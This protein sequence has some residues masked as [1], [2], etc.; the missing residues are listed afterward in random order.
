[1]QLNHCLH[2]DA[3]DN[4]ANIFSAGLTL[5]HASVQLAHPFRLKTLTQV[6]MLF[7]G[8]PENTIRSRGWRRVGG[9]RDHDLQ[10][11]HMFFTTRSSIV[12]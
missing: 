11:V 10:K 3:N 9:V 6:V 7:R 1:M 5:L 4:V 12:A 2:R 8:S